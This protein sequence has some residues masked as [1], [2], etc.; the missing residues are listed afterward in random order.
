MKVERDGD[1]VVLTMNNPRRKDALTPAMI[2]LMA[3]AWDEIDADDGI[4][5][6]ILYGARRP[7]Q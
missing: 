5:V 7:R 1:V 4:R 3:Q 6:P 2:T